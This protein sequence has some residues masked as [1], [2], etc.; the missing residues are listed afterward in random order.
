MVPLTIIVTGPNG[1]VLP[2]N[3]DFSPRKKEKGKSHLV[4]KNTPPCGANTKT[5]QHKTPIKENRKFAQTVSSDRKDAQTEVLSTTKLINHETR[6]STP[7]K[8]TC[9]S[10]QSSSKGQA[11]NCTKDGIHISKGSH[12]KSRSYENINQIGNDNKQ[13]KHIDRSSSDSK[14]ASYRSERISK[15]IIRYKIPGPSPEVLTD[16]QDGGRVRIDQNATEQR[17]LLQRRAR[18]VSPNPRTRSVSEGNYESETCVQFTSTNKDRSNFRSEKHGPSTKM[19]NLPLIQQSVTQ[20][21]RSFS[22]TITRSLEETIDHK[23]KL[24]QNEKEKETVQL[25]IT[26]NG[27]LANSMPDLFA[28]KN[29]LHN[30]EKRIIGRGELDEPDYFKRSH[31]VCSSCMGSKCESG[32]CASN[33]SRRSSHGSYQGTPPAERKKHIPSGS[34]SASPLSSP[35]MRRKSQVEEIHDIIRKSYFESL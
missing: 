4:G 17:R 9:S 23:I 28:F 14:L 30:H 31:R 8:E 12:P 25:G 15:R 13:E 24:L 35:R 26:Q 33:K 2:V 20:R 21:R 34:M 10:M 18:S 6:K 19:S 29:A 11:S 7:G 1:R 22:G 16:R 32:S 27:A 3:A 5:E